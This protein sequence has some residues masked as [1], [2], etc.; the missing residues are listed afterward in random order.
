MSLWNRSGLSWKEL[1]RRLFYQIYEDEVPGRCAELAYY[2]LFSV[3]PLLLFLTTL[4]GVVVRASDEIRAELFQLVARISPSGEITGLLR[5][6]LRE[7]SQESSG[8]KLAIGLVSASWLASNGMLAVVRSLN[9][10]FGLSERRP[11]WKVRLI[12]MGLTL[13]F[14][15]LIGVALSGIF[16]GGSLGEALALKIGYGGL[17]SV[18]W[19]YSRWPLLLIVVLACFEMIYNLAPDITGRV[20][21]HWISPGAMTGVALWVVVSFGL[22]LYVVYFHT[23]TRTYGSLGVVILL[24][25]W[26]YL[27]GF[28]L[29]MGGEVNSELAKAQEELRK[30]AARGKARK[31]K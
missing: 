1:G 8:T 16:Y 12:A 25:F 31:G 27:T 6:T 18:L 28:A 22:R 7:I 14:S 21:R 11:W 29:L 4:L 2:F 10:A 17:F 30:K 23:Y 3:F 26:F 9:T 19:S 13:T 24:L 5:E 20:P 15:V